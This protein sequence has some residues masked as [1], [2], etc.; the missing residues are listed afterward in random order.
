MDLPAGSSGLSRRVSL[1]NCKPVL[2]VFVSFPRVKNSPSMVE[3]VLYEDVSDKILAKAAE[4]VEVN[5]CNLE[6]KEKE[7]K[8]FGNRFVEPS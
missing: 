8:K 4:N 3:K 5:S 6:R 1:T 2:L 7:E